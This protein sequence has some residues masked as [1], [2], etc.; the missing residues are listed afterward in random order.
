[1]KSCAIPL[2]A[3]S[4][5]ALVFAPALQSQAALDPLVGTKVSLV[6]TQAMLASPFLPSLSSTGTDINFSGS[7][8]LTKME[9]GD[10]A[11][12]YNGRFSGYALGLGYSS[13]TKGYLG[14]FAIV[15]ASSMDGEVHMGDGSGAAAGKLEGFKMMGYAAMGGGSLRI[16]GSKNSKFA[17]G[18]F[19]GPGLMYFDSS[20]KVTTNSYSSNPL[21]YG[22]FGGAQ[23]KIILGDFM[24]NPGALWTA[25]AEKRSGY[26]TATR[27]V[28]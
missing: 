15:N 6:A 7:Y 22:G 11:S 12:S 19:A 17:L 16:F 20:F 4:L 13:G 2:S 9:G 21:I 10:S 5:L 3:L 14:T 26:V 28:M 1:M 24:F 27:E 25:A 8:I 18:V 23:V